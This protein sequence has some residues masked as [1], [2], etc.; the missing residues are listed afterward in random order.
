[1]KA[2]WLPEKGLGGSKMALGRDRSCYIIGSGASLIDLAPEE[3]SYLDNHPRT[4]AFNKYLLFWDLIGVIPTDFFLVDRHFPAHIVFARSLE[5]SRRLRK[6]VTLYL[7]RVYDKY[8]STGLFSILN[9]LRHRLILWRKCS[10]WIPIGI[11]G[12]K[13]HYCHN[14]L[15]NDIP[16]RWA[17]TLDDPLYFY[18]GSLVSAI[19]LATIIYPGYD[20]KLLG[21]DLYSNE[22]FYGDLAKKHPELVDRFYNAGMEQGQHPTVLG[23]G[24][25]ASILNVMPQIVGH[26]KSLGIELF[27]C[28]AKSLLVKGR[29]CEYRPIMD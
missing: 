17:T 9:G 13:A 26:L 27:C 28:N 2:K 19:N 1:M 4:L 25:S 3:R 14:I 21:V 15:S 10:Y 20:I 18:R 5:I 11:I 16:F 12:T 29:I 24:P 7:E 22:Y 8:I 6:P 23:Q